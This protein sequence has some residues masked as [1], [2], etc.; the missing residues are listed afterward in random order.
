MERTLRDILEWVVLG[1][2]VVVGVLLA[3]WVGGWVFT[4]LGKS[5]PG[6]LRAHLD[7]SHLRHSHPH[8]GRHRLRGG[9]LLAEALL[10]RLL[11]LFRQGNACREAF[12]ERGP[13]PRFPLAGKAPG[14]PPGVGPRAYP[15]RLWRQKGPLLHL[16]AKLRCNWP[17]LRFE[18]QSPLARPP[19]GPYFDLVQRCGVCYT[20]PNPDLRVGTLKASSS[21]GDGQ[22]AFSPSHRP[23]LLRAVH[24]HNPRKPPLFAPCIFQTSSFSQTPLW[25]RRPERRS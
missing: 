19:F 14:P 18:N 7:P 23:S 15:F 9:L 11:G 24:R 10:Q 8:R 1:L 13:A 16:S 5:P 3:L 4:F 2:L 22:Y 21:L 12:G 17:F 6:P 20:P 25:Q